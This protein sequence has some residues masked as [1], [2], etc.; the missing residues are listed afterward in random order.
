MKAAILGYGRQ[1]KV[2]Y[3]YWKRMGYQVTI[4]D[5]NIDLKVPFGAHK[6][7]GEAYLHNLKSYDLLIRTPGIHPQAIA[8]ANP[9]DPAILERVT[10]VSNEFMQ[11]CPTKNIIGVTGTKGKSTTS[12][13]IARMLEQAGY[14]VH[15][16]GNI[17]VAPLIMLKEDI[18]PDDWVVL[19]MANFQLIDLKTSPHIGVCLM[20]MPEHLD[21]HGNLDGYIKAKQP[22]FVH[23]TKHDK[24]IYLA[25]N[26]NSRAVASVG[27]GKHIAYMQE[28]GALVQNRDFVIDAQLI[29]STHD[30]RLLGQH[31]WQNV[32]AAITAV[33][34]VTQ[35]VEAIKTTLQTFS[36]LPFRIELRREHAGLRFYND[37]FASASEATIA[38]VDAISGQKILIAGG[39]DRMIPLE[40]F[41]KDVA[42]RADDIRKVIL[43]GASAERTE[44]ALRV[45]GFTKILRCPAPDM[46]NIVKTAVGAAQFGDAVVLSPG[47]PS[48][49]MFANFEE[50]GK[51]FNAAVEAL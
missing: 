48:F 2:A 47:F 34:Q 26:D 38:A 18:Q 1:G 12:T 16:G 39:F 21:W 41:A 25:T 50:R 19:E 37:S 42:A 8:R 11:V 13:L 36:G 49:D 31:N 14:R 51:A 4:C 29:C 35:N 24:A 45:A 28:P 43:V 32:C 30:L 9:Q 6:Q 23:Q 15:L 46:T 10:T 27:D 3:D 17:G 7:L 20:V 40:N 5:Q 22:I 33:W 44:Q